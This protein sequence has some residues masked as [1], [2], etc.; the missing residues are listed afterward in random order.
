[1]TSQCLPRVE[2]EVLSIGFQSNGF[3]EPLRQQ[4]PIRSYII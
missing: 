4:T 1:M 3:Q 2:D